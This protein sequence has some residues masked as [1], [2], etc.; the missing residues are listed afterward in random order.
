MSKVF[1]SVRFDDAFKHNVGDD[2]FE[3]DNNLILTGP[4]GWDGSGDKARINIGDTNH[5]LESDYINGLSLGTTGSN[6]IVFNTGNSERLRI[7]NSGNVGI[8]TDTPTVPL[9]V[10]GDAIFAGRITVSGLLQ[11]NI[12]SVSVNTTLD[13]THSVVLVTTGASDKIITLPLGTVYPGA[14]YH[15]IKVDSDAGRVLVRRSG[16]D[17]IDGL[18]NDLVINNQHDRATVLCAGTTLWYSI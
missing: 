2:G 5:F 7:D 17:T 8:G 16:S 4:S 18:A 14:V 15:V 1:N 3:F 11:T 12:T 10:N 6:G 13:D 9:E